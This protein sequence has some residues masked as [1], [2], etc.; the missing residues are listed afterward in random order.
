LPRP[1]G[2]PPTSG[3]PLNALDRKGAITKAEV[4]EE[5]KALQAKTPKA[6]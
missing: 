6:T 2:D 5:F 1:E 3:T 4:L